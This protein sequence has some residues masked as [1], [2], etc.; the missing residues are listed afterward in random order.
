[1][2]KSFPAPRPWQRTRFQGSNVTHITGILAT[3]SGLKEFCSWILCKL[4]MNRSCYLERSD[5]PTE[6]QL[7]ENQTYRYFFWTWHWVRQ[8]QCRVQ[9]S[10]SNHIIW[11]SAINGWVV[12]S[13][14]S[15]NL[16]SRLSK[17][18]C[19]EIPLRVL[20]VF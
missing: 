2:Q 16:L 9:H 8:V 17:I 6:I 10:F 18:F 13:M 11:C 7:F 20:S 15:K 19:A 5:L 4:C 14:V 3:K 12:G 1:M